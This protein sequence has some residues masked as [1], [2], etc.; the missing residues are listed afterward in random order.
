MGIL[1]AAMLVTKCLVASV[2]KAKAPALVIQKCWCQ[3]PVFFGE[4]IQFQGTSYNQEFM[5]PKKG[6]RDNSHQAS[7]CWGSPTHRSWRSLEAA[8]RNVV[9]PFALRQGSCHESLETSWR[10]WV[11]WYPVKGWRDMTWKLPLSDLEVT[12]DPGFILDI[13]KLE[14][15]GTKEECCLKSCE[16]F[17]CYWGHISDHRVEREG[18]VWRVKMLIVRLF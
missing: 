12:C 11:A 3:F 5:G 1:Q 17:K 13:S 2:S 7:T 10:L 6:R 8:R 4:L 15:G 9:C 14:E 18:Q 16:F